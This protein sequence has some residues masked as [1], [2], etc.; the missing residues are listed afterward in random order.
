MGVFLFRSALTERISFADE[1]ILHLNVRIW[2]PRSASNY[3]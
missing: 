2:D 3:H 1:S